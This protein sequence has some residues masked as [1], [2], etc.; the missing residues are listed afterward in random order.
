MKKKIRLNIGR[1]KECLRYR[2]QPSRPA[3]LLL[4]CTLNWNI[5][6]YIY[7]RNLTLR[8]SEFGSNPLT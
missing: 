1:F 4:K 6:T 3:N 7:A 8:I 5:N 2:V